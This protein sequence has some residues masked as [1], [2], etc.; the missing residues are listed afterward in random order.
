MVQ[1][2]TLRP[3]RRSRSE[4]QMRGH[5]V[6]DVDHR[7]RRRRPRQSIS[8]CQRPL[9][10]TVHAEVLGDARHGCA[11][12]SDRRKSVVGVHENLRGTC[13][14]V[15]SEFIDHKN[16]N[17]RAY[18]SNL[19]CSPHRHDVV[20][21]VVGEDSNTVPRTHPHIPK[22]RRRSVGLLLGLSKGERLTPV[23][24]PEKGGLGSAVCSSTK[25]VRKGGER[26]TPIMGEIAAVDRMRTLRVRERYLVCVWEYWSRRSRDQSSHTHRPCWGAWM[27]WF[28]MP[29]LWPRWMT[30]VGKSGEVGWPSPET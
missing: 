9:L 8:P 20:E 10:R 7:H 25:E 27:Y 28:A 26:H 29:T 5:H 13:L 21:S 23:A 15:L 22:G 6:V 12:T 2:G 3:S 17:M 30:A 16:T 18:C 24:P 19:P 1:H 14:Y 11:V 4:G